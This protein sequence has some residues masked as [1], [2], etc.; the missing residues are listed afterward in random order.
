MIDFALQSTLPY[1][2]LAPVPTTAANGSLYEPWYEHFLKQRENPTALDWLDSYALSEAERRHIARSVQQFQLGEWA[3]GRGLVRR[4]SSHPALSADRWFLPSLQLFIQEEQQHSALLGRFLDRERIPR[5]SRHWVDGVFRWLR[6]LAGLEV[7]VM[8]LVTA[9]VL[10]VPFYQALRD[11]TRS[12]LLRGIC[13]SILRDEA[14]HLNFQALTLGLIRRPLSNKA[15]VIC[16]QCH[17]I[18]F[19]CTALVLWQQHHA[20]FQAAGWDF[21]RF[22][23][24][25]RQVFAR[26]RFRIWRLALNEQSSP[27][28]NDAV[29][30]SSFRARRAKYADRAGCFR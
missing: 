20:V 21:R 10:A 4:A 9:E 11:A 2:M 25:A 3:R 26:L 8:V 19:H 12:Q 27:A 5:L 29:N 14:A 23:K 16:F 30:N 17:S 24:H 28:I 7:C 1:G 6:K 18:L 13:K 22:W 15:R